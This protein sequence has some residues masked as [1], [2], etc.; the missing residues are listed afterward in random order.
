MDVHAG[1][2][3]GVQQNDKGSAQRRDKEVDLSAVRLLLGHEATGPTNQVQQSQGRQAERG[4]DGCVG[5][6]LQRVN[7]DKMSASAASGNVRNAHQLGDLA[8]RNGDGRARHEGADGR[9]G[10]ELDEPSQTSQAKEGDDGARD[11]GQS[12]RNQVGRDVWEVL[13]GA[14]DNVAGDLRH[15]SDRLRT[16]AWGLSQW[17]VVCGETY[18]NGD[19]LGGREE[20]VD[21]DTHEGRVKTIL[22]GQSGQLSIGHRLRDDNSAD[23]GTWDLSAAAP[24][25]K[26]ERVLTGN[27]VTEEP[28]PVVLANPRDEGKQVVDV[29]SNISSSGSVFLRPLEDG[30][31]FLSIRVGVGD[32]RDRLLWLAGVDAKGLG[33]FQLGPRHVDGDG[34]GRK[35]GERDGKECD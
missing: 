4:I 9:Q 11:D 15:D 18:A 8:S 26:D 10:N 16:L 32:G 1:T 3:T 20:P 30:R 31:V 5:Q 33:H 35:K 17:E 25:V 14:L 12:G 21:E 7:N 6:A 27:E 29:A 2:D 13:T 22:D 34:E 23:G 19:V 24:N 28:G